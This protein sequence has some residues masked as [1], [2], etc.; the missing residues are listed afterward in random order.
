[1]SYLIENVNYLTPFNLE[2]IVNA[3]RE[4]V[5]DDHL[6]LGSQPV[7]LLDPDS[8]QRLDARASRDPTHRRNDP[9][10]RFVIE[11]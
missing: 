5:K 3:R 10:Q 4:V 8:N 1:M 7:L 6:G 11:S 2:F 9:L